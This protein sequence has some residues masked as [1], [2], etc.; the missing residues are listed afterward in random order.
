MYKYIEVSNVFLLNF[1]PPALWQKNVERLS[2]STRGVITFDSALWNVDI[3]RVSQKRRVK[4]FLTNR[5]AANMK[6][7]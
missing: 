6:I 2:S 3:G 1:Y 4:Q 7:I 5:D